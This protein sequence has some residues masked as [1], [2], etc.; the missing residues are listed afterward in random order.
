MKYKPTIL[1]SQILKGN[2]QTSTTTRAISGRPTKDPTRPPNLPK[3]AILG[4]LVKKSPTAGTST[5]S[6]ATGNEQ[7]KIPS[8]NT[9]VLSPTGQKSGKPS[10]A[11]SLGKINQFKQ[12]EQKMSRK[13]LDKAFETIRESIRNK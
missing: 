1:L 5:A 3:S 6:P 2:Y 7:T 12:T 10:K 11:A 4:T 13:R 8:T 9:T